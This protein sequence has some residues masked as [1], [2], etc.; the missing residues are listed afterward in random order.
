MVKKLNQSISIQTF[1]LFLKPYVNERWNYYTLYSGDE[2]NSNTKDNENLLVYSVKFFLIKIQ[3]EDKY[4][5]K[6]I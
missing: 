1:W 5:E 6:K 2:I 3:L 4:R